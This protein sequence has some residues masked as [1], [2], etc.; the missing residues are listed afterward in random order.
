MVVAGLVGA[1][2]LGAFGRSRAAVAAMRSR[3][4]RSTIVALDVDAAAIGR[5]IWISEDDAIVGEQLST[6]NGS[7]NPASRRLILWHDDAT[8]DLTALGITIPQWFD[9]RGDFIAW[10]GAEAV[11]VRVR[12]GEIVAAPDQI[13]RLHPP[14]GFVEAWPCAR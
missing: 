9:E 1:G 13:P 6:A 8:V 3:P 11:R 4:R 14:P 2:L 12:T 7:I 10:R 5:A